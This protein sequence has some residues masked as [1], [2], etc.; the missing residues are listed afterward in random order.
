MSIIKNTEYSKDMKHFSRWMST[1]T[2]R[3]P[4]FYPLNVCSMRDSF[5]RLVDHG[6]V[7]SR[8]LQLSEVI[9]ADVEG[10]EFG[11]VA[12]TYLSDEELEK[13]PEGLRVVRL[14]YIAECG[15][16]VLVYPVGLGD[17]TDQFL[18][19]LQYLPATEYAYALPRRLGECC[20]IQLR[21]CPRHQ[22]GDV[23]A[24]EVEFCVG[25]EAS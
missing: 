3:N 2:D 18:R 10:V 6:F 21:P 22:D 20:T 4:W 9:D 7:T 25:E 12:R 8:V 1:T 13:A 5:R 17:G 19:A 11:I 24:V 23:R 14:P 15:L 16:P